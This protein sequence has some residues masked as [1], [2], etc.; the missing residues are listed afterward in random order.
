MDAGFGLESFGE[1]ELELERQGKQ[2]FFCNITHCYVPFYHSF[3]F[4]AL[5]LFFFFQTLFN[6]AF[7]VQ[8]L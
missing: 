6:L 8:S 5:L 1:L 3:P 7:L 4:L 2:N